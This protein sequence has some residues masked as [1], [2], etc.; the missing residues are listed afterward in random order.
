RVEARI[1]EVF[2]APRARAYMVAT[3]T[4]ANALA[5][6]CLCPPWATVYAHAGSHVE[7]DECAAPEFYTGGS[8]L[9]LIGGADARIDADE[10]AERIR[11]AAP[12]DIHNVQN[13][14]VSI[15]QAT[16]LGAIYPLDEVRRLTGIAHDAGMGVHMDG[17]R[18]AN[19]VAR[20][21]CSPAE[22]SWKAGVDILCLGATK[23][24]AMAAETVVIFDPA[25]AREFELRRKRAGH[26]FSKMRFVAAQM[27]AY[28]TDRLWLEM[29]GHANAMAGRLASGIAGAPG[30]RV[31]NTV[32][33]NMIFAEIP[34]ATH[35]RLQE[36]GARYY[37]AH[38]GQDETGPGDA[39]YTVRLVASFETAEAE[40]ERFVEVLQG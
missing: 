34:L 21:G 20:L 35:R 27:D 29:A 2:E 11:T 9:T 5:L 8:K 3:G 40:V 15:T 7:N 26:L 19:A 22:A 38:G 18:F 24:G 36:A 31:L 30:C 25:K 16:E 33:A 4:A 23:N 10:L 32:E 39:P 12:H 1:R 13:G 37:A 28:L 17:T 6:A 14:A